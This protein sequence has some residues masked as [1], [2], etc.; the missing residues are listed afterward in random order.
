MKR[1]DIVWRSLAAMAVG[2]TGIFNVLYAWLQHHHGRYLVLREYLP[3]GVIHTSWLLS[4]FAGIALFLLAWGLYKRKRRAW[5]LTIAAL[6]V[7][8]I[9]HLLKGLDYDAAMVNLM[10][11]FVLLLFSR[12]YTVA[13]DPASLGRSLVILCGV[14]AVLYSYGLF[15]FYLLD[16]HFGARFD[17]RMA[18]KESG[19]ML[20]TGNNPTHLP[21]T[22]RAKWFLD[23][24]WIGEIVAVGYGASLV[25]RPVVYRRRVKPGEHR[26]AGEIIKAWGRSPLAHLLL[27]PDK[28]YFFSASRRS[29]IG[30]TV[31]GNVAVA[32]GDPVGPMEESETII[33]G[34]KGFCEQHDWHPAFF[35]VLPE[36]LPFY[37]KAGFEYLKVGEEAVIDL[38]A[39]SLE[40]SKMKGVRNATGKLQ[41]QGYRVCFHRPP[42]SEELLGKLKLISDAWLKSQ[43]GGEK[44]FALGWF[45]RRYLQ[46]STVAVVEGPAG[47]AVA[48]ANMLVTHHSR[49]GAVDLMRRL[50]EAPNGTMEL[51]FASL[52]E[53]FRDQGLRGFNL[54]LAPLSGL[55]SPGALPAERVAHLFYEHF[56]AFY[57]YK[58]LRRFKEKFHPRWE[59]RYLVYPAGWILPKVALAVVRANSG[60]RLGDYIRGLRPRL[61][62]GGKKNGRL[63]PDPEKNLQ[64]SNH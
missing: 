6:A 29:V 46:K 39:F 37:T 57:S 54:G 8:V 7:A 12:S 9:A 63:P 11:L 26:Q 31:V 15:G 52:A 16:R 35:Q 58:G 28:S 20:F 38:A 2:G 13:S 10:L 21:R 50:P 33:T 24:L 23:S 32:L 41:R 17:F 40:G 53:Y 48:F 59:P 44:R 34:F 14:T 30:Y 49:E 5:W 43:H 45:D 62:R 47:E 22:H 4:V 3:L 60:G 27:L 56:N 61:V 19:R 42:L 25:F 51:L 64:K 18:A 55:G 36:L 1:P